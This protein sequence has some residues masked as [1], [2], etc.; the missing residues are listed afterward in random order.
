MRASRGHQATLCAHLFGATMKHMSEN[1][2]RPNL[3][4]SN[5]TIDSQLRHHSVRSYSN[6][7]VD[8][9]LLDAVIAAAQAPSTWQN[10]NNWSLI[11]VK[12]YDTR[13]ALMDLTGRNPFMVEAPIFLVW[14]AD[15][16]R[17]AAAAQAFNE[18]FVGPDFLD[19]LLVPTVDA[20]LAA[21]NAAVAAESLGLGICF[22]GGIRS[23]TEAVCKL[24][25]LPHYA[26]PV[27]GMS[28]GW[29]SAED[30]ATTKPRMPR[31][32]QVFVDRYDEQ[33]ALAAISE[34]DENTRAYWRDQ[35]MGEATWSDRAAHSWNSPDPLGG[36]VNMKEA[37]QKQGYA[38]K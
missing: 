9:D 25:N 15:M 24:L 22:V 1:K 27:T 16:S 12:D 35:G 14:V 5:P 29:P 19:T 11:V 10:G 37:V 2:F 7:P 28:L 26:F 17:S 31:S 8:Q 3:S 32:G 4:V 34:M 36:R 23:E 30:Q 20:A 21:Q 6:K 33:A 38:L 18:P 13:K